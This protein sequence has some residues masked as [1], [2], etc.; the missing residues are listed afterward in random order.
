YLNSAYFGHGAYGIWAASERYF[1][2]VPGRL[3]L[4]QASLLAGLVQAPSAYDPVVH[5]DL[6]R[7]RQVAV[8][9]AL[10]RGGFVTG[11]E[12]ASAVAEPLPL[13]SASP[14]PPLHGLDLAPGPAFLWW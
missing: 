1:G 5:P 4:P 10:V 2:V 13:R 9:R 7:Q 3:T 11:A 14:L 8:L 6:A 12:A